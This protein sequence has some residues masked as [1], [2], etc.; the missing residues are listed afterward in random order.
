MSS[1]RFFASIILGCAI[2]AS[3]LQAEENKI[4]VAVEHTGTDSI[5]QR[6]VFAVREAIRS[7]SG[8]KLGTKIEA[9]VCISLTTVDPEAK[10]S[11][12]AGKATISA[13]VFTVANPG[14][15]LKNNPQSWYPLYLTSLVVTVGESRVDQYGKSLLA[16]LDEA[17]EKYKQAK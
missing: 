5:G 9:A 2:L 6:L 12:T 13:V 10:N 4:I 11:K 15:Y 14:P 1:K 16:D 8:Y 17:Y 7:S 3:T